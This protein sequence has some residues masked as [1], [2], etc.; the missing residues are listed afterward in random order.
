MR[1]VD[2]VLLFLRI[3][4]L[5]ILQL[6]RRNERNKSVYDLFQTCFNLIYL[7]ILDCREAKDSIKSELG[8]L[9]QLVHDC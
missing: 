4:S 3:N 9:L 5:L 6:K 2:E 8:F 1:Y 7:Y